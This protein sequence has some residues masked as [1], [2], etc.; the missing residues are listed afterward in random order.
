MDHRDFTVWLRKSFI[1]KHK[2]AAA[3][4]IAATTAAAATEAETTLQFDASENKPL[5]QTS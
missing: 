3:A 2:S 4:S 1:F 5:S